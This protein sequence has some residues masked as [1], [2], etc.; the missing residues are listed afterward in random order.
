M[1]RP[2]QPDVSEKTAQER[3]AIEAFDAATK[4][5]GLHWKKICEALLER[6]NRRPGR[7]ESLRLY[8]Q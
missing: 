6:P 7:R 2:T 4:G 1:Y 8:E 5:Y 3:A